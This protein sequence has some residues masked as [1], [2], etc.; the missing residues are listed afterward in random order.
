MDH[1][2]SHFNEADKKDFSPKT[3]LIDTLDPKRSMN[4]RETKMAK[5]RGYAVPTRAGG[6]NGKSLTIRAVM[7]AAFSGSDREPFGLGRHF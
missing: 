4:A 7:A 2:S 5:A 1:R 3:L 6:G